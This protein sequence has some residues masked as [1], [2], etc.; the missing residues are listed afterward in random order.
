MMLSK[1]DYCHTH[2]LIYVKFFGCSICLSNCKLDEL[3]EELFPIEE[4]KTITKFAPT[5]AECNSPL[6]CTAELKWAINAFIDYCNNTYDAS[7]NSD[8][9]SALELL[10]AHFIRGSPIPDPIYLATQ[11]ELNKNHKN[12][13]GKILDWMADNSAK[14]FDNKILLYDG[15]YGLI[16]LEK[17]KKFL[18]EL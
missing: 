11:E 1:F 3:M 17:F 4:S 7:N 2:N 13:K 10:K 14:T 15:L 12:I 9:K 18:E 16:P 8:L 5:C 6:Q